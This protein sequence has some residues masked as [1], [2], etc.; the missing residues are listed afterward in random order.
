MGHFTIQDVKAEKY[1]GWKEM[2]D[3]LLLPDD[4]ATIQKA[5]VELRSA[6]RVQGRRLMR[7]KMHYSDLDYS[8][9]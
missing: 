3:G 7:V 2:H 8:S 6:Q 4:G 9:A 5:K 1:C